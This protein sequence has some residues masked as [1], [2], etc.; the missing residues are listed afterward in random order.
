[1]FGK[2]GEYFTVKRNIGFE[3]F[4]DEFGISGSVF[5]CGGVYLDRPKIAHC[6]FLFLSIGKLKT[7]SVKQGFLGLAVFRLAGPQ[8]TFGMFEQPFAS[9]VLDCASFNSWHML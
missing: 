7:P 8:K 4:I 3:K 5:S 6:A 1:M 2:V 9:F